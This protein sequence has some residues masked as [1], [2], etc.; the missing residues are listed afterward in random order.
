MLGSLVVRILTGEAGVLFAR[1]RTVAVLYALMAVAALCVAIFLML[2]LFLW[3]ASHL[4]GIWASLIFAGVFAV[5]IAVLYA[6]LAAS[7]RPKET[8]RQERLRRDVASIAGVAAMSNLPV[9]LRS[10][11][12]QKR[13]L[14][15]PVAAI[16]LWGAVRMAIYYRRR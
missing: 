1:L 4:G 5:I 13:L 10:A 3:V 11:R 15:I 6:S 2:A 16:G 7:R 8:D 12:R 14:A 9:I